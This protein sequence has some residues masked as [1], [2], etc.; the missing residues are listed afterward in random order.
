MRSLRLSLVLLSITLS[1]L[2]YA[3]DA[4]VNAVYERMQAAYA[5]LD[6][7]HLERVYAPDAT[8]LPRSAKA[9]VNTRESIRKGAAAF[10]TQIR[11]KGGTVTM[12]FRVVERKRFDG[13]VIDNGYVRT[14]IDGANGEPPVV[15]YGKFL[16]AI[17]RQTDGHWAFVS[18]GDSE[19]PP[20]AFDAAVAVAGLKFDR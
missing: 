12:Q 20:A 18:D 9:N 19:T 17:A 1:H 3:S 15:S 7:E 8:Y 11:G 6:A 10:I 2:A 16:T 5:E 13:V 4:D 14:V